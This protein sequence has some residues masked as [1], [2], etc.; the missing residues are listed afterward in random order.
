[1]AGF[2]QG[3]ALLVGVDESSVTALSLAVVGK[4][5]AALEAVLTH[6]E[7]CGYAAEHV[8]V[9]KGKDATRQQI[10][11]G[12]EWLQKQVAADGSG[13]ATAVVY[14]SGHGWRDTQANPPAYYLIP[15]DVRQDKLRATALRG[16]DLAEAIAAVQPQRLLVVLDCCHAGGMEVKEV[17][18]GAV[19]RYEPAAMPPELVLGDGEPAA[20]GGD[21]QGFAQLLIGAGRAVLSSSTGPQQSYVRSDRTMSI[22][23]YHLIEALTGHAQPQDGATEVL[24]SDVLSYVYRQV[25]RTAQ[26]QAGAEQQPDGRITGNFAVARLLGGK[27]LGKGEAA[28]DPLAALPAASV[29]TA[30]VNTGG[31]AYITGNVQVTHGDFVGRDKIIYT[32][33]QREELDDYLRIAAARFEE[34]TRASTV[35]T[36]KLAN[37]YKFLDAYDVKDSDI[38]FGRDVAADEL[39]KKVI[40]SRLTVVHAPSGS[41]K[42]SLLQAGIGKRLIDDD[43]LPLYVRSIDPSAYR[44]PAM[45]VKAALTPPSLQLPRPEMLSAMSFPDF[46]AMFIRNLSQRSELLLILD[47]FEEF[48]TLPSASANLDS[49]VDALAH[50]YSDQKL[51]LRLVLAIRKD[52]FSEMTRLKQRLPQIINNEFRLE[53]MSRAEVIAAITGPVA[54]LDVNVKFEPA[55]QERLADDLMKDGLELFLLQLYCDRLYRENGDNQVIQLA[56]YEKLIRSEKGPL[57]DYVQ[58]VIDNLPYSERNAAKRVLAKLTTAQDTKQPLTA[59]ELSAQLRTDEADYGPVLNALITARLVRRSDTEH[60]YVYELTHDLVAVEVRRWFTWMQPTIAQMQLIQQ[61][62]HSSFRVADLERMLDAGLG[63][64]LQKIVPYSGRNYLQIINDLVFYFATQPNGLQRLVLAAYSQNPQGPL[65]ATALD[66]V[67]DIQF[68]PLPQ[69]EDAFMSAFRS[70]PLKQMVYLL[71]AVDLDSMFHMTTLSSRQL[72]DLVVRYFETLPKGLDRLL[73]AARNA[74]PE[75]RQLAE[76]E[77]VLSKLGRISSL[78]SELHLSPLWKVA[79]LL[80]SKIDRIDELRQFTMIELNIRLEEIGLSDTLDA[81]VDDVVI[82]FDRQANGLQ[83][84][85]EAIQ[86]ITPA[87]ETTSAAAELWGDYRQYLS[88]ADNNEAEAS[89]LGSSRDHT[90]MVVDALCSAFRSNTELEMLVRWEFDH[91]LYD[92]VPVDGSLR[93]VARALVAVYSTLPDGLNN[94]VR[95][96]L[97]EV[98]NNPDLREAYSLVTGEPNT[99]VH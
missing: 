46:L 63:E 17:V 26:A 58:D 49:F 93:E 34:R 13:N 7:R 54:R 64:D 53:P 19:G 24:V 67:R 80:R 2:A 9:L 21:G 96:A 51:A 37:P 90:D 8:R 87:N 52:Y 23:T 11:D 5:V 97:A 74:K 88:Q 71:L 27:G 22:F 44:D 39:H 75:N 36:Q 68:I 60:G 86:R 85:I 18:P 99:A 3:Y 32:R 89:A 41:G 95:A 1:M 70:D 72:I 45:A 15:Y 50:C 69:I 57:S 42:T 12:V 14:Y 33:S 6:S 55:L 82:Y 40:G 16:Q 66:V 73:A 61:A 28:P 78:E 10:V 77:S 62:L 91:Y 83:S 65:L 48:F 29:P 56:A 47:Q 94:L 25:P 4:D 81:T 92:I 35:R 30:G 31:G 84:L 76:V 59:E 98:P 20:K 43:R 38:F 79:R